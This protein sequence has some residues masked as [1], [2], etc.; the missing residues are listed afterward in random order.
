[1]E[2]L[3]DYS[4]KEMEQKITELG[5]KKY[6][7]K[8]VYAGLYQGKSFS[9]MSNLSQEFKQK[10][11]E[12]FIA[13][14]IQIVDKRVSQDGTVKF[15]YKL[16]DN[17]IIEGVLMKYKYGYT[18]CVSTQVGCRMRCAFCASGIDGLIRNLSAGEILGQVLQVNKFLEGSLNEK[19]KI[20]N[21]V[22]MGSGEPL[23][24]YE[25]V[26]KF[27]ELINADEGLNVSER[28]I[29]LSTCGIVEKIYQLADDDLKITLTISL[30]APFDNM[31]KKLMPIANK[32]S[33]K[34][35]IDACKYYF[36]KT[37][38]RVIFE[39]VLI[40]DVNTTQECI[41]EIAKLMHGFSYHINVISLNNVEEK[42]LK[43]TTREEALK[44]IEKLQKN[45]ISATL[46]R[47][48]GKDIDGACGQLRRKFLKEQK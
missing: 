42:D 30:H 45:R 17:N 2:I 25:N 6:R 43:G 5:E 29:S 4:L 46:R 39:Y 37:G 9:E 3:L 47:T 1:M 11:I 24:N 23:D 27:L 44:F 8:Q 48:M 18:L 36:K 35:I 34:Q 12:N 7:A 20:T 16:F 38:R 13:L 14:P 31:R 26:K 15:L 28:N 32:Y 19:R 10:L 41:N 21:I 33:I 40:K 22:L